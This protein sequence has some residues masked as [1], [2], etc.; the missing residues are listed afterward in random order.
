MLLYQLRMGTNPR[1]VIIDLAEKQIDVPRYELDQANQE[2]GSAAMPTSIRRA[3]PRPSLRTPMR[4]SLTLPPSRS[5]QR[6]F[7]RTGR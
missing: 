6:N 1:R 5:T 7:I 2:H 3:V 4:P